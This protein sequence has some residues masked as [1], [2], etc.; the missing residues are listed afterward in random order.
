MWLFG[1]PTKEPTPS[2][3]AVLLAC[4]A[5]VLIVLGVIAL[6][7]A[8]RMDVARQELAAVLA[9]GG[10]WSLGIGVAIA[11]GLWLIRRLSG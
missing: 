4:L 2:E 1:R 9:E 10:W 8:F 6:L 7:M 11:A 5:V 3:Y